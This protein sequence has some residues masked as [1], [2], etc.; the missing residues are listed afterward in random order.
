MI[1]YIKKDNQRVYK[2][3]LN[4]PRLVNHKLFDPEKETQREDY[5]YSLILLFVP[6]HD[7]SN[8]LLENETAR[9]SILPSLTCQ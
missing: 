8:L 1:V 5:Y 7:E 2:K 4:T 6:F 9:T 3:K